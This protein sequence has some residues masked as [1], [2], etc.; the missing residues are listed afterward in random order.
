MKLWIR[1]KEGYTELYKAGWIKEMYENLLEVNRDYI[2]WH[3]IKVVK[4]T[5]QAILNESIGI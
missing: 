3:V 4:L 1:N 2:E 5:L